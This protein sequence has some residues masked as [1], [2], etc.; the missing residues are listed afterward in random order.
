[1]ENQLA[2]PGPVDNAGLESLYDEHDTDQ[3]VGDWSLGEELEDLGLQHSWT[4]RELGD[5]LVRVLDIYTL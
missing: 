3:A 4:E 5:I 1:M 2:V